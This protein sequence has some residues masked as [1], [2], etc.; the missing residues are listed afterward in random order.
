[1]VSTD[2]Q[3]CWGLLLTFML[4]G[5]G[6]FQLEAG[7]KVSR[8]FL[9]QVHCELLAQA[10]VFHHGHSCV[11]LSKGDPRAPTQSQGPAHCH[12]PL[13][14]PSERTEVSVHSFTQLTLNSN[15]RS[16][17]KNGET[18]SQIIWGSCLQAA[19]HLLKKEHRGAFPKCKM[20]TSTG[21][22]HPSY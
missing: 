9:A 1:M 18:Q 20:W 21:T 3:H 14:P 15:S 19:R 5:N 11:Q 13:Q 8:I 10:Q 2:C 17:D 16:W 22:C 12:V 6:K 4:E 7:G